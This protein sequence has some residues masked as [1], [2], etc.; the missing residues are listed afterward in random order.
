MS[1]LHE[2]ILTLRR[3]AR[4][5]EHLHSDESPYGANN[6]AAEGMCEWCE[7]THL[8]TFHHMSLSSCGCELA[9]DHRRLETMIEDMLMGQMKVDSDIAAGEES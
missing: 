5:L 8:V 7:C 4:F 3:L 9:R 6:N 2:R 1:E